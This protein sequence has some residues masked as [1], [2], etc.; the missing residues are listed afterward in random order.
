N[1]FKLKEG[2]F[3]PHVRKKFFK[4][5]VVKYWNYLP[6]DMVYAPSLGTLKARLDVALGK[7]I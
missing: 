4:T 1:G 3:R 2:K 6:R 5:R 7:L